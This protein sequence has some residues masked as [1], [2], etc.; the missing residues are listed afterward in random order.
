MKKA[1]KDHQ[2]PVQL[3]LYLLSA[4]PS[5]KLQMP[6]F[7]K[8]IKGTRKLQMK[9]GIGKMEKRGLETGGMQII[10]NSRESAP[11]TKVPIISLN[12]EIF[13]GSRILEL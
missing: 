11:S 12:L 3:E 4:H 2:K 10:G 5:P 1:N 8:V 13:N 6:K 7:E 9:V